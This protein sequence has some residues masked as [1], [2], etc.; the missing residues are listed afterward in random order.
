[1]LQTLALSAYVLNIMAEIFMKLAIEVQIF[2]FSGHWVPSVE[3]L[4]EGRVK[5][6]VCCA[7]ND[8]TG[9]ESTLS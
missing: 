6:C 7:N 3:N 4:Y 9:S 2:V 5:V 8:K 1:V